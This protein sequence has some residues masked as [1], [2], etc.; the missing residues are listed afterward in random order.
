LDFDLSLNFIGPISLAAPSAKELS[1][2]CLGQ[3]IASISPE[4]TPL[5]YFHPLTAEHCREQESVA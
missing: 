4:R 2:F 5:P 1:L 3:G